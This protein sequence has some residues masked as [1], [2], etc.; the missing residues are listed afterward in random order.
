M[1]TVVRIY[2]WINAFVFFDCMPS[3]VMAG[4]MVTL[5]L[6]FWGT[7]TL[8]FTVAAPTQHSHQQ[9]TMLLFSP[10]SQK[11]LLFVVHFQNEFDFY[12]IFISIFFFFL[13]WKDYS[14]LRAI[15]L[16][17]KNA[18]NSGS[19]R[20][21]LMILILKFTKVIWTK[22]YIKFCEV[23]FFNVIC[24]EK[25]ST[26]VMIIT[27]HQTTQIL[28]WVRSELPVS[29][30]CNLSDDAG[31]LLKQYLMAAELWDSTFWTH[32]ETAKP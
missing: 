27:T 19:H 32:V 6:V 15:N 5:S 26:A 11:Y 4:H 24:L 20:R 14:K 25:N 17:W 16:P 10:C 13:S 12:N 7:S 30:P 23:R 9:W 28:T 3:S 18:F 31:L 2:F 8:F 21:L 1:R 29:L 22:K